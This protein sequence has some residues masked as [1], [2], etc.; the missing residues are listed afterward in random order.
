MTYLKET[1]TN[2]C[3]AYFNYASINLVNEKIKK[4]DHRENNTPRR[5]TKRRKKYLFVVSMCN[6]HPECFQ[7]TQIKQMFTIVVLLM[8]T[9]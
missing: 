4:M 1:Q 6:L 2:Y 9:N 3:G 7:L 8:K 5:I